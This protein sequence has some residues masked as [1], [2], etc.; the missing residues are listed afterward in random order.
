VPVTNAAF[1]TFLRETRYEPP[2]ADHFLE[3]WR[4]PSGSR[5]EPWHWDTPEGKRDHP[6]TWVSLEDARVYAV[7]AGVQLPTEAQWQ[8][9]AEGPGGRA[10][11]W[12]SEFDAGRCNGDSPGTTPV[13]AFPSGASQEGVLDLCGNAWE[14]T[15]SERDDGHTRYAMIRGGCHLR[16]TGSSW[17]TASGAQ[18]CGVHE[19]VPLLAGGID[20]LATV[21]FRCVRPRG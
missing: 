7:W 4:R 16:V 3:D 12:G 5:A 6:V 9:A 10:W 17:Y 21:G 11:P 20:R 2:N 8:R 18:P 14:W 19:K 13:N 15:E 1:L